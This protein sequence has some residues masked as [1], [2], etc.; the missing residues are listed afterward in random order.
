MIHAER[1][2]K[3]VLYLLGSLDPR[4][5]CMSWVAEQSPYG[6][7]VGTNGIDAARETDLRGF[8][9]VARVFTQ[10]RML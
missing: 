10:T 1:R 9:L 3:L 4:C 7:D 5:S 6:K 2:V 8:A